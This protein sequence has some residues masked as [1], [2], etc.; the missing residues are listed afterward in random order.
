M[1][2]FP[3]SLGDQQGRHPIFDALGA[4]DSVCSR[5]MQRSNTWLGTGPASRSRRRIGSQPGSSCG[6]GSNAA[7]CQLSDRA[8]D[9]G[10]RLP[11]PAW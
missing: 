4:V 2:D 1:A 9:V 11:R 7:R 10:L 6:A 3:P 5:L 8:A